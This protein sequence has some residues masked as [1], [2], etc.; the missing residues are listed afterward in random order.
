MEDFSGGP[1]VKDP[2][3]DAEDLGSENKIPH[4]SGQ[5][6]HSLHLESP[7]ATTKTQD[8]QGQKRKKETG[9]RISDRSPPRRSVQTSRSCKQPAPL[10]SR[11]SLCPG[12]STIKI[13]N[14]N[15]TTAQGGPEERNRVQQPFSSRTV[16]EGLYDDNEA[17]L[18]T[19]RKQ[20][21][22]KQREK[23]FW[24]REGLMCKGGM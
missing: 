4:G 22:E 6:A 3:S 16:K 21:R 17:K 12:R 8:S 10:P 2:L 11:S 5:P 20:P 15:T 1:V 14:E 24:P 7:G 23:N 13:P 9:W 18:S 19:R